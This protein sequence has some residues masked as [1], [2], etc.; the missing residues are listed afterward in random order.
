M[1]F[2]YTNRILT[3][4]GNVEPLNTN[5]ITVPSELLTLRQGSATGTHRQIMEETVKLFATKAYRTILCTYRD[6]SMKEFN[7]LKR[8]NGDFETDEQREV[9]ENDLTA[10]GIFGLQ[11]PLRDSIADDIRKCYVAGVKVIMCTGDNL[12]TARAISLEAGIIS[13]D[14]KEGKYT[15]MTGK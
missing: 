14:E 5:G 10:I 8:N 15:C 1:L 3:H 12:D 9:L 7:N 13:K 2:N 6:M 4:E 11:D